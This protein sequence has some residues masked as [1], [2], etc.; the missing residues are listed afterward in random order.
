[1]KDLKRYLKDG[2]SILIQIKLM[3][4]FIFIKMKNFYVLESLISMMKNG[5]KKEIAYIIYVTLEP[6]RG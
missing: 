3:V 1:M 5:V 2:K 4:L 6:L